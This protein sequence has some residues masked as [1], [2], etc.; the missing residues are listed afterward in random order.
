MVLLNFLSGTR[1]LVMVNSWVFPHTRQHG[2]HD[3]KFAD[4]VYHAVPL[5]L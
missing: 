1:K 4:W 5:R 3:P 2:R